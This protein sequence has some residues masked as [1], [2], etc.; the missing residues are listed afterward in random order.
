[1]IQR[2]TLARSTQLRAIPGVTN[3][4][5]HIGRARQGEE[6]VGINAAEIWLRIDGKADYDRTISRI[7]E[8]INS[9]PGL[10]RDVQTYLNER[11]EEVLTGST[12]P[13]VVRVSG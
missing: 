3:F 4:G 9:Y 7:R 8:I 2:V 1:E 10:Y 11:I 6:V 5:A 12:R 13:I